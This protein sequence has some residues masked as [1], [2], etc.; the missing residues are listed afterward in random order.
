[1]TALEVNN[2]VETPPFTD[3]TKSLN[4]DKYID[5]IVLPQIS[6]AH[7]IS[8]VTKYRACPAGCQWQYGLSPARVSPIVLI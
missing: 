1:M 8:Y 2:T 4:L 6:E 5:R 7:P 3:M